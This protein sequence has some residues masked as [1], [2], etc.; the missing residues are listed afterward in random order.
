[1][2]PATAIS[3]LRGSENLECVSE[4]LRRC[5]NIAATVGFRTYA[6]TL[7]MV[8]VTDGE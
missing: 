6:P 3:Q 1:M 7:R 2:K 5:P 4:I 8:M